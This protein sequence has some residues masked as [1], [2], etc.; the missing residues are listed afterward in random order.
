MQLSTIFQNNIWHFHIKY[1]NMEHNNY[2][3]FRM[4]TLQMILQ[5]VY[6]IQT[7][8]DRS[9]KYVKCGKINVREIWFVWLHF[10]A[11]QTCRTILHPYLTLLCEKPI[12]PSWSKSIRVIL[13]PF[14]MTEYLLLTWINSLRNRFSFSLFISQKFFRECLWSTNSNLV[15]LRYHT[16]FFRYSISS[17]SGIL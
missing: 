14:L 2:H 13:S 16:V 5:G 10:S 17:V 6:F 11:Y 9:S 15:F 4:I 7:A 8:I 12:L 3:Y 1:H